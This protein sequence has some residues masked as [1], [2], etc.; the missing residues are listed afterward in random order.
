MSVWY[1][2]KRPKTIKVT[3]LEMIKAGT[4]IPFMRM[5]TTAAALSMA[6][7]V[8]SVALF[9][10]KGLN[11]GI[12]FRG[13]SMIMVETPQRVDPGVYRDALSTLELG[14]V[15]VQEISDPGKAIEGNTTGS[16]VVR[17]EQ[18]N[19]GPVAHR[20]SLNDVTATIVDKVEGA[21]ILATDTVGAKVSGELVTAGILAVL[22]AIGGVL[23]YIW[24]RFEWQFSVG[25]VVALAHDVTLTIGVFSLLGLEFNLSIIAAILTIVG[26]SLNDTVVVY[27]RVREN[28]RKFKKMTLPDLIDQS[29]NETLSRT[30]MTSI[31]TLLALIALY[32]LG[33]P[34]M[35]GFT[36]AMIWGV[37]V[38]TYSSVF[39][40]APILVRLGV[41]RD[42][43]K[44]DPDA[45]GGGVQFG[46]AESP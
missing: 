2:W 38:G 43:S 19:D 11:Y 45:A 25:A 20:D 21:K 12:D 7:V 3:L 39:V 27:D 9:G 33:G 5:K 22:L 30:L 42:W 8:A 28:L 32:V 13:G 26:Y 41:K 34:V 1:S 14:D 16:V 23:V 31:T 37:V 29:L 4:H 36:F 35:A 46:S 17:I 44:V 10:I 15:A 24:L 18:H 40:A 6:A